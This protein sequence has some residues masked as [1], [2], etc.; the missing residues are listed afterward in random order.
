M[1]I[2]NDFFHRDFNCLSQIGRIAVGNNCDIG[3]GSLANADSAMNYCAAAKSYKE[4]YKYVKIVNLIVTYIFFFFF[5]LSIQTK[6]NNNN[7]TKPIQ[8]YHSDLPIS[9][10]LDIAMGLPF[11]WC[12]IHFPIIISLFYSPPPTILFSIIIFDFLP[13]FPTLISCSIL[14]LLLGT[15]AYC[16]YA[17]SLALSNRLHSSGFIPLVSA[18]CFF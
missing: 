11:R 2:I 10:Y 3:I 9:C 1:R 7:N 13:Y 14:I 17:S 18:F 4:G 8:Q 15:I 5:F 16:I 12:S 6:N